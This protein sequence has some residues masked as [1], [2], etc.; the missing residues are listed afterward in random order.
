MVD[1]FECESR[2]KVAAKNKGDIEMFFL[3]R[4]KPAFAADAAGLVPNDRFRAI[5]EQVAGGARVRFRHE[6]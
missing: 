3:N 1:K 4:L 5:R 2:G 6:V